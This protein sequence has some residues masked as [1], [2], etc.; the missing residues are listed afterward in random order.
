MNTYTLPL[1]VGEYSVCMCVCV[2][3]VVQ[4]CPTLCNPT[5]C[6]PPGSV[7]GIFQARILEWV[8]ISFSRGM[9]GNWYKLSEGQFGN[10]YKILKSCFQEKN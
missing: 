1:V 2:H 6:S 4:L 10:S 3:L 8:A 5:Y 7:L 9:E